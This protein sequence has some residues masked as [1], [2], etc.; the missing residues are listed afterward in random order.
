MSEEE[1]KKSKKLNTLDWVMR[2]IGGII[3]IPVIYYVVVLFA[4]S[5]SMKPDK[6]ELNYEDVSK[7][8]KGVDSNSNG[9][10]DDIE[11]YI[12]ETWK[13]ENPIIMKSLMNYAKHSE[14]IYDLSDNEEEIRKYF[15][16]KELRKECGYQF[17][18]NLTGGRNSIGMSLNSVLQIGNLL[19]NTRRREMFFLDKCIIGNCNKIS[20]SLSEDYSVFTKCGIDISFDEQ[21][22]N[23]FIMKVKTCGKSCFSDKEKILFEKNIG[24]EVQ[25]NFYKY[26][27]KHIENV[28]RSLLCWDKRNICPGC[29]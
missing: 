17:I 22:K 25:I 1:I 13:N 26:Y 6:P 11:R 15:E 18:F 19:K 10:R 23:F 27:K 3:L 24:K 12:Q 9:V 8:L 28:D 29:E 16:I 21:L 14:S 20:V 4:Y 7:S 5:Q 2:I